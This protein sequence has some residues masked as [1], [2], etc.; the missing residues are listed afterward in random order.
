VSREAL[1]PPGLPSRTEPDGTSPSPSHAPA[2]QN[3]GL[4]HRER[5][6][7]L[8]REVTRFSKRLSK[9]F[10]E[11]IR[12]DPRTLKKRVVEILR[13]KLPPFA[14]RPTEESIT[15]AAK[16]RS[17]GLDWQEIYGQVIPDHAHL[18]PAARRQAESNLRS[19]LRSRRNARLRRKRL[20]GFIAETT[21]HTDVP[22]M[23]QP[24]PDLSLSRGTETEDTHP[25]TT[26]IPQG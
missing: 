25:R 3:R 11:D 6:P 10:P 17:E 13:R 14:G 22:S 19:A 2:R 9:L 26:P 18:D 4:R 8:D 15:V 1:Q 20:S 16:L 12:T 21:A 5:C 23:Q 24:Q 7:S